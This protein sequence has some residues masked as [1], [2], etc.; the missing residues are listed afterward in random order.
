V[1]KENFI[2]I[3]R[4]C[5]KNLQHFTDQTHSTY[6]SI[7]PRGPITLALTGVDGI[8]LKRSFIFS[9]WPPAGRRW[10]D[11]KTTAKSMKEKC[12]MRFLKYMYTAMFAYV[13]LSAAP[14]FAQFEVNPDH[15]DGPQTVNKNTAPSKKA[16]NQTNLEIKAGERHIL[17]AQLSTN[18]HKPSPSIRA[19]STM[20][21][22]RRRTHQSRSR[23]ASRS[24]AA[25]PSLEAELLPTHRE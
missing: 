4:S 9:G 25:A 8:A 14:A 22:A 16:Q 11:I 10:R 20:T 23:N 15:F 6:N 19:A 18:M 1:D 24:S 17:T 21:V 5:W 13:L 12:V 3:Q 2:P 7:P